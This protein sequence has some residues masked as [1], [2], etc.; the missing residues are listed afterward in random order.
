MQNLRPLLENTFIGMEN[1]TPGHLLPKGAFTSI[2]NGVVADNRLAK[3]TGTTGSTSLGAFTHNGGFGYEPN[4]GTKQIIVSRNGASN[5]QLY[6]STNGTAYSA[7]GSANLTNNAQVNFLQASNSL[8]GFNGAEVIDYDGTTVTKNR[9]TVPIGTWGFWFHNYLFVAGVSGNPNRVYWSNLGTPTVFTNT[10]FVDINA[11]DGDSITGLASLNDEL[12]VFK[13][14]STWSI[15]GYSGSSFTTDTIAGQNTNSRNA[16]GTPSHQSL[17]PVG[18]NLY[19]LSFLGGIP[20]IRVLQQSV[21]GRLIDAG[22]Y[23]YDIEPTMDGINKTQ[24]SKVA[25][26]YD[27]KYIYWAIP[28]GSS[29]S[30]NLVIVLYPALSQRASI[31]TM[32]SWVTWSGITPQQFF[33][34]TLSGRNKVYFTDATTTGKVSVFDTSI[35]TDNGTAVSMTIDTRDYVL[36]PQS[37]RKSKYKYLYGKYKAGNAGSLKIYARIDQAAD[38]GLQETVSLQG[39][40]PGLGPTGSFTLGVSVLGGSSVFKHRTTFAHLTG[41]MLGMRFT[42]TTANACEIY[43]LEI[44]GIMKGYR[45]D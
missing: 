13:N 32:H 17:V 44:L 42:E 33:N 45:D 2:I 20:H 21:F 35:Y 22:I 43:D 14:H 28:T 8:F 4:G 16:F 34:S 30:N 15:T 39:M 36:D 31:G 25:G 3:R 11:N 1:R 10:D 23:S 6:K 5:A 27:G 12:L 26:Y 38:F 19:Y 40:S 7:I 24:L 9:I 29:T 18:R 41:T 37:A